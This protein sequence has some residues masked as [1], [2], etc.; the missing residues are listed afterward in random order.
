VVLELKYALPLI[1]SVFALSPLA[2][3]L[4]PC[5][6]DTVIAPAKVEVAV[7]VAMMLPAIVVP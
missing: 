6:E 7:D 2:K 5:P 3:V 4:V 1:D